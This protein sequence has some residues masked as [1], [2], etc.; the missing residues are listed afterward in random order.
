MEEDS[1]SDYSDSSDELLCDD[2]DSASSVEAS[3]SGA[4]EVRDLSDA[5][6][7]VLSHQSECCEE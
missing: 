4:Q 5:L 1:D 6:S 2:S 3:E 7:H